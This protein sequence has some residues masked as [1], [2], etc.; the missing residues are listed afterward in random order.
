MSPSLVERVKSRQFK[1]LGHIL[2][3][4][5]EE[6]SRKYLGLLFVPKHGKR[7]PG[8]QWALFLKYTQFTRKSKQY[9]RPT[10]AI[11]YGPGPSQLQ[12][13]CCLLL[14]SQMMMMMINMHITLYYFLSIWHREIM[15]LRRAVTC[16]TWCHS[17]ICQSGERRMSGHLYTVAVQI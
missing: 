16:A 2:G 17:S 3:L 8:M 1:F 14:R 6:P 15:P 9:A 11:S 7:K 12:K 4:P 10:A 5:A 13:A